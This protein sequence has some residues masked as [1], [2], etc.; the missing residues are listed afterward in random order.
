MVLTIAKD[1][2]KNLISFNEMS[3]ERNREI[4]SKGG[5][6]SAISRR[7][8]REER[9]QDARLVDILRK[10]LLSEITSKSLKKKIKDLGFEGRSYFVALVTA[11]IVKSLK[12]GDFNVIVK[13]VE[14]IDSSNDGGKE[15]CKS[16]NNLIEAIANVRKI[17]SEAEGIP[18]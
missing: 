11:A 15:G 7:K 5:I 1:K 9:K 16:F 14:L 2:H 3:R 6:M 12:K 13:L 8:M 4:S 18:D 10:L 17:K